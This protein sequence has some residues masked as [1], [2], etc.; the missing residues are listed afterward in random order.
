MAKGLEA[1]WWVLITFFITGIE[2][3]KTTVLALKIEK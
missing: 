3:Q 1:F 2:S